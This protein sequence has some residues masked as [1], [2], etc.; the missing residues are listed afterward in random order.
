MSDFDISQV[1][2]ML[3][4]EFNLLYTSYLFQQTAV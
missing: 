1:S 4:I 3:Y 2:I